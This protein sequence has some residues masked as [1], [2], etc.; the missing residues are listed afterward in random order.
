VDGPR[1]QLSEQR[2][3][4]RRVIAHCSRCL[5]CSPLSRSPSVPCSD[6]VCYIRAAQRKLRAVILGIAQPQ[7]A[8]AEE[9]REEMRRKVETDNTV[10]A[11]IISC[12]FVSSTRQSECNCQHQAACCSFLLLLSR[13][14]LADADSTVCAGFCCPLCSAGVREA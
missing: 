2:Y 7:Q 13:L 10:R 8:A 6:S 4:A 11:A 9:M 1:Q 14:A 3:S 5:L 12:N